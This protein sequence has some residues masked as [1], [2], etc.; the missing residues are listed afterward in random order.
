MSTKVDVSI[1]VDNK[2]PHLCLV[3]IVQWKKDRSLVVPYVCLDQE[4][5][6]VGTETDFACTAKKVRLCKVYRAKY[7][8]RNQRATASPQLSLPLV[9]ARILNSPLFFLEKII[10]DQI[11]IYISYASLQVVTT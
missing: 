8:K 7:L 6:S 1:E 3:W 9:N 2:Y 11:P 10:L 4:E 5:N